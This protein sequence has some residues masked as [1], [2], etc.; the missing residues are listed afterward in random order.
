MIENNERLRRAWDDWWDQN[1]RFGLM[2]QLSLP[3]AQ[4]C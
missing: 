3:V 1:L 4:H 2:D